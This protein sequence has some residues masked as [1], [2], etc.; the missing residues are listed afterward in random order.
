MGFVHKL[1]PK[2]GDGAVLRT[3]A[4]LKYDANNIMFTPLG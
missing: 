4:E 1:I 2:A 3:I